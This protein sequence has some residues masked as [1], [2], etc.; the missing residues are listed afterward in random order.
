MLFCGLGLAIGAIGQLLWNLPLVVGLSLFGNQQARGDVTM[1]IGAQIGLQLAQ[2]VAGVLLGATLGLLIGTAIIHV[3]LMMVGGAR[4]GFE[5]TLRALAF[6]QGSTAWLNVIPCA[7]PLVLVVWVLV[8][9]IIGIAR[10]HETTAGK[11]ALAI[12]LPMIVAGICVAAV[13]AIAVAIAV[14]ARGR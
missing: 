10:A 6:A 1:M 3:C 4:H 9:E 5:T 8:L 12:F 14:S 11:A 7:G 13:I 2:S